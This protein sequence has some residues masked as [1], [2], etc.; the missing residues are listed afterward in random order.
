MM[1][2]RIF[3]LIIM[4]FFLSGLFSLHA[5]EQN[6]RERPDGN[7]SKKVY[8]SYTANTWGKIRESKS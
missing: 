2:K 7:L 4:A 3:I 6:V 5:S 8:I 1:S